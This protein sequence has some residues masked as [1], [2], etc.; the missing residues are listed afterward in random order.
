[1]SNIFIGAFIFAI[2]SECNKEM[3]IREFNLSKYFARGR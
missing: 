3:N 2:W 1:M